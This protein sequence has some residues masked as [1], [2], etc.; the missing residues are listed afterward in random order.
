MNVVE[1]LDALRQ[2]GA[3]EHGI[4]RALLTPAERAARERFAAWARASGFTVTQDAV[5]NLFARRNGTRSDAKPILVGSHLDTVPTGGAYDGAYGVAAALCALELLDARGVATEHPID[6]VAWAGEEGS[7]FPLGC[8]GSSVFTG[9]NDEQT[10]RALVGDDGVVFADALAARDGGL[11]DVP[12][13][14]DRDV[15]AYLELHVEQGPVLEERGLSLG[16]V[17]AIA[18]QRRLRVTVTGRSGH[19]GTMPM[20]MRADALCAAAELVLAFERAAREVGDAV[21]TVGRLLVEPNGTNIVP[22]CVV[23]SLDL[24]SPDEQKLDAISGAMHRA[25]DAVTSQ[26]GVRVDVEMLEK[27][28]AT[29]MTPALRDAIARAIAGL[30]QR[31]AEVPS[32]AGHDAMCL[33]K[34]VPAAMIFVPSIGG[35]SHVREERTADR[36]LL[37]GVEALAASIVEVDKICDSLSAVRR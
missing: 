34:I 14:K 36:D 31:Y 21:A 29:P 3:H 22:G 18:A 17:T 11:L 8:L 10:V 26:R 13:R 7:R 28:S 30:G 24:R 35:Q 9:L 5:S 37:L 1:R 33:G 15:A 19:A 6:A 4:D 2:L 27:R 12:V 20:A 32:G 23:F 16:I 25:I